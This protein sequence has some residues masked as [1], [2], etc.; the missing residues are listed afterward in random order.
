MNIG[1][2]Q[3]KKKSHQHQKKILPQYLSAG[4]SSYEDNY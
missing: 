4:F 1:T 3:D 2:Y